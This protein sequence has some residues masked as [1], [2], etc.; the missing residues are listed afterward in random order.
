MVSKWFLG[1]PIYVPRL[2]REESKVFTDGSKVNP[3]MI[4]DGSKMEPRCF[5]DESK[6]DPPMFQDGLKMEPRWF[7]DGS[8]V[9]PSLMGPRWSHQ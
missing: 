8:K 2:I 3:S 5:P 1:G 9:V 4:Q 7:L 6:G